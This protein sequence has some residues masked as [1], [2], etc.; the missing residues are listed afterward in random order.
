M[1]GYPPQGPGAPPY[2]TGGG[3]PP[4][5]GPG[6]LTG[7]PQGGYPQSAPQPQMQQQK[8][9]ASKVELYIS[10][11]DLLRMDVT[12]ASD[13]IAILH[14]YDKPT[15]KWNEVG[16][17][18]QIKNT[19]NPDFAT[20]FVLNY[21]F[22][23]VQKLKISIYDIDSPNSSLHGADFLGSIECNLGQIVSSRKYVKKLGHSSGR[24]GT[25]TIRSE[26]VSNNSDTISLTFKG[27]KLDKKD[28]LSKSDPFL[29]FSRVGEDGSFTLVHRSEVINNT[30]NPIWRPFDIP[31]QKLCNGDLDR[32]IK[33]DC[34]DHDD[35]GSHDLIG[36]F[37]TNVRQM[38]EANGKE[39]SWPCINPKKQKKKKNYVNSGTIT[40]TYSKYVKGYSFLDFINRGCQINF[41][42]AIDFTG[43]NGDPNTP[44]SLH[45]INPY[46][47]NEYT[48][49]LLSVGEVCEDYD[50]DKLFPAL[51]FGARIPPDFKVHHEF[52]I[53]FNFANPY[54]T[55]LNGILEAYQSAVRAVQLYGPTNFSP[56][57]RHVSNFAAKEAKTGVANAYFIL[58]ILTDGEI[59]D[60]DETIKAIVE[61]SYLPM[62]IIIV[63]V[64]GAD[65]DNMELLDAD[66]KRLSFGGRTAA[67]DIVQFVPFRQF[68]GAPPH[69]LPKCVL[70]EV[71]GQVTEY[72]KLKG[73]APNIV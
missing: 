27:T 18:E 24:A 17:T 28:F 52:P 66:K 23:E 55:G 65:F 62:S 38:M 15:K 40:L 57:I 10:C 60:M 6:Y 49:A 63:G 61:A 72:F 14:L 21:F 32:T 71:P 47:P 68:R 25:I 69:A 5:Q 67:R 8:I 44:N 59:T 48:V 36:S 13:P 35:D 20:P 33:V 26:E 2:P 3:Y 54:C 9:P 19:E 11:A 37:T 7:P 58:L 31:V 16:R 4:A 39:V 30:L 41:T 70:A 56:V 29:E 50:T 1:A 22:E 64:G 45:Y 42:V 34:Y 73:I 43:S 51:G 53:N 12:S 46:Q